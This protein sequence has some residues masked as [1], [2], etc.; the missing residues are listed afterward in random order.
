MN[1]TALRRP[2]VLV[3]VILVAVL[4]AGLIAILIGAARRGGDRGGPATITGHR[5]GLSNA[6]FEILDGVTSLRVRAGD[7]GDDLY[8]VT[9]PDGSGLTP[10]VDRD[11]GNLRLHLTPAGDGGGS[12]VVD[13]ILNPGVGWTLRVNGGA[14]DVG[15]DMTAGATDS[16]QLAGGASRIDVALARPSRPTV[17]VMTGGVDQFALRLAANTPVRVT[18]ASGAGQVTIGGE[19]HQ[20][21]GGGQVFS[22]GGWTDGAPGVDVRAQAGAGG[23]T[24]TEG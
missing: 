1:A 8:R 15:I 6:T 24:V 23:I 12:K 21:V 11:R 16:I 17:V 14:Q 13:V 19:T 2:A 4:L 7:I 9:V 20:G 22:A 3:S 18:A 5:D 10:H